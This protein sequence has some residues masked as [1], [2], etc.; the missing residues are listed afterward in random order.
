MEKNN[1]KALTPRKFKTLKSFFQLFSLSLLFFFVPSK[2]TD[3]EVARPTKSSN[4]RKGIA[5]LALIQHTFHV[6]GASSLFERICF[7]NTQ[8]HIIVVS[9]KRT[10][11]YAKFLLQIPGTKIALSV[12]P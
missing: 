8:K 6:E 1:K 7:L 3:S 5:A 11:P 12:N 10:F 2:G 4:C 9:M